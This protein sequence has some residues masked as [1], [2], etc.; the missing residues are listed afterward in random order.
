MILLFGVNGQI[1]ARIAEQVECVALTRE[2]ADFN[3]L[4]SAKIEALLDQHRPSYIINAAGYTAVDAAET[5][6]ELAYAANADAP[7]LLAQLAQQRSI[8]FIHFSTDYVFDGVKG[9][10]YTETSSTNP[11]GVYAKSK[12]LGE[13]AV[14]EAGGKVFRLQWVYDVRGKNFYLTM[15]KLLAERPNIGVVADQLGA[16]SFAK[17]IA[18][19][20]LKA[21][22]LPPG[23]YHLAPQG[24]TSWHGFACAIA[25]AMQSNCIV[26]PITT[27]EYPTAA[28][29]PHDTR[30]N[31]DKLAALGITLP[32][33]S[34]GLK[35]ALSET[36]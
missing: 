7:K 21:R 15:R 36:H 30:M 18:A 29:R 33:W 11:L 34:D 5:Q 10:P 2:Q 23:L 8:P 24:Y 6:P 19:T 28:S 26:A 14:L 3:A 35:E 32:H 12:L 25:N 17:H 20:V 27:A 31:C 22:D 1:G 16:P 4:D 9:A 13:Q